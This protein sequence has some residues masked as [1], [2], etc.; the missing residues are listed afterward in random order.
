MTDLTDI[1]K[2][3]HDRATALEKEGNIEKAKA[4]FACSRLIMGV[5]YSDNMATS[6]AICYGD[7]L[8][9]VE[10]VIDLVNKR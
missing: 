1:R 4:L 6:S 10:Q 3:L 8:A 5:L 9:L 7:A 2:A